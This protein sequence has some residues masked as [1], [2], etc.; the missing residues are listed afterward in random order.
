MAEEN[1]DGKF[2]VR[3]AGGAYLHAAPSSGGFCVASVR[4][5]CCATELE[6]PAA[7]ALAVLYVELTG[8][9]NVVIEQAR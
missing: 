7:L 6:R 8:D 9:C 4:P 1:K 2:R 3:R 5:E